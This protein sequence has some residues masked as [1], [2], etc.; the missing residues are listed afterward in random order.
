MPQLVADTSQPRKQPPFSTRGNIKRF[1][2]RIASK[3]L[4]N[5]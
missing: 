5:N 2:G 4:S 3:T 1:Q